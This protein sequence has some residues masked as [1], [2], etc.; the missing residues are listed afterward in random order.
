MRCVTV[1]R[2]RRQ[3][4][5]A[6]TM[7]CAALALAACSTGNVLQAQ[8]GGTPTSG[9]VAATTNCAATSAGEAL[10][11]G[12]AKTGTAPDGK[13]WD[14]EKADT[15][16]Y[17]P[18]AALSWVQVPVTGGQKSA[19][20]LILLYNHGQYAKPAT[21]EPQHWAADITRASDNGI[22]IAYRYMLPGET[23]ENASGTTTVQVTVPAA[24][25]TGTG[26]SAAATIEVS[27]DLP[28]QATAKAQKEED[29]RKAEEAAKVPVEGAFP[30][31]G[32]PIPADAVPIPESS[33]FRSQ[34]GGADYIGL[35]APS[36]NIVCSFASDDSGA[37]CIV[38][39]WIQDNV[40]PAHDGPPGSKGSVLAFDDPGAYPAFT[41]GT[42]PA[43]ELGD[44]LFLVPYGTSAYYGKYV[45][46]S[47]DN[48]L[49]CW[50]SETG[51]GALMN[52]EGYKSF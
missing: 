46:G 1:K 52:R 15:A 12:L 19:V 33:I 17:D 41:G 35:G 22:N 23:W 21:P 40:Y 5:A 42:T 49:T 18:C 8:S 13:T 4:L 16:G 51:H 44:S 10:E 45:C 24:A 25:A 26:E 47:A 38:R 50:N 29:D 39:S 6:A 11:A 3:L 32:G 31:A 43:M 30:G 27:G 28:E 2:M 14:K 48:G 20:H 9:A 37:S 7:T 34:Y 36:G